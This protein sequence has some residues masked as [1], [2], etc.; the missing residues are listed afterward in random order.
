[1]ITIFETNL[2]FIKFNHHRKV[3]NYWKEP[4]IMFVKVLLL[5]TIFLSVA[6]AGLGIRMLL[7]AHG[8][9]PE[10]HVSRNAEMRKRGISCVR[11]TD[12]GCNPSDDYTGCS[13]CGERRL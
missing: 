10:T 4:N 3:T 1:M 2:I 9:F 12:V 8:R 7:K 5:S 13:T 6:V 11:D